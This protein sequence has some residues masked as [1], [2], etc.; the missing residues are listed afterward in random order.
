M[1]ISNTVKLVKRQICVIRVHLRLIFFT[2]T[3]D[4]NSVESHSFRDVDNL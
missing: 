3:V 2:D 4:E 1:G